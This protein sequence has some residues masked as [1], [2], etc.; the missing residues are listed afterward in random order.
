MTAI[1]LHHPAIA[2]GL[3]AK[4]RGSDMEDDEE[5][6]IQRRRPLEAL[7]I[8]LEIHMLEYLEDLEAEGGYMKE[9]VAKKDNATIRYG[10]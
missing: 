4:T 8:R 7:L 5:A 10:W 1:G 2:G 3:T 9:P 6:R